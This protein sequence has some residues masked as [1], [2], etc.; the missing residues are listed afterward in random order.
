MIDGGYMTTHLLQNI[1][2]AQ[3]IN[4]RIGTAL[5]VTVAADINNKK[6]ETK[7]KLTHTFFYKNQ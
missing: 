3:L 2:N 1:Q 5:V 7:L 4:K 6:V